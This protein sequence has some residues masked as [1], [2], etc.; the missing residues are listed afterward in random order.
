M[1]KENF[2]KAFKKEGQQV[3]I[4]HKYLLRKKQKRNNANR[5]SFKVSS[6]QSKESKALFLGTFISDSLLKLV[7]S[8]R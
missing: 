1:K 5:S 4:Y 8:P 7:S 3:S 2:V 6:K